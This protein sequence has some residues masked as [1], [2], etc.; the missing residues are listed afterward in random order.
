M[1]LGQTAEQ[2][3]YL[4]R[5]A[6]DEEDE[7]ILGAALVAALPVETYLGAGHAFP[8]A[9]VQ[10]LD[11]EQDQDLLARFSEARLRVSI[12]SAAL[13]E[14]QPSVSPGSGGTS[15]GH[16]A[17]DQVVRDLLAA[18]N[19]GAFVGSTHGFQGLVVRAAAPRVVTAALPGKLHVV[20]ELDV[21]AYGVPHARFFHAA[22]RLKATSAGGNVTV[23]WANAPD[24][25]DR[26]RNVVRRGT[27]P[28]DAAPATP[29]DGTAVVLADE[30]EDES[31]VV[32]GLTG[33]GTYHFAHW[34]VYEVEDDEEV[35]SS[36]V[37]TSVVVA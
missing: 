17:L 8:L 2:L 34:T 4:L 9:V 37:T 16:D 32:A 27:N 23:S 1:N 5:E 15:S 6:T 19:D 28:G 36:R 12:A 25:Y 14:A 31:V 7:A 35:L 20:R 26:V 11:A 3:A 18:L 30:L 33:G 10:V 22:R 21:V 24:R 13:T 29:D